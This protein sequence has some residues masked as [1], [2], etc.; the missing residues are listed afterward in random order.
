[1]EKILRTIEKFI[2]KKVY[3]F[4]QPLYHIFLA[5]TGMILYR[6]PS[7]HIYVVA[8]TGTKGKSCTFDYSFQARRKLSSE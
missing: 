8:I 2:P 3:R 6:H 5:V 4:F 7:R 1:M